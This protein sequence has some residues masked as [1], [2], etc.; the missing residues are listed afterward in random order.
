MGD[1]ES[2][3]HPLRAIPPPRATSVG[4]GRLTVLVFESL[5]SGDWSRRLAAD[6]GRSP[7][8]IRLTGALLESESLAGAAEFLGIGR[9]GARNQKELARLAAR[10]GA[11]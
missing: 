8:E 9:T 6:F 2:R 5:G 4:A 3:A 1:S 7:A 10:L 11:P